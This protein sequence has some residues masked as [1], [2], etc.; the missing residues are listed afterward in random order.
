MQTV[1]EMLKLLF[2]GAGQSENCSLNS[3]HAESENLKSKNL[4]SR[5]VL[6]LL[7]TLADVHVGFY[8]AYRVYI[9]FYLPL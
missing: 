5:L 6:S 4:L 2:T 7:Q 1:R 3:K 9:Y 8:L